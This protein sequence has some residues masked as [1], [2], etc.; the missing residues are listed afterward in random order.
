VWLEAGAEIDH[1]VVMLRKP[2][3]VVRSEGY[4]EMKPVASEQEASDNLSYVLFRIGS[5]LATLGEYKVPNSQIWFPECISDP[6]AFH[7][8]L[9]FPRPVSFRRFKRA[10]DRT[11]RPEDIHFGAQ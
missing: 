3:D 11:V 1:A 8:A 9:V 2:A 7:A 10:L 6:E 5:L 4:A